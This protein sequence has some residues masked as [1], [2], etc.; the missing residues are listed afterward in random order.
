MRSHICAMMLIGILGVVPLCYAQP[1]STNTSIEEVKK[2]TQ[3]L[4]Q[5]IGSYTADQK[6]EA[7]Q[8][9]KDSLNKLDVIIG[10]D[11]A[12]VN[13][14]KVHLMTGEKTSRRIGLLK[15]WCRL[16]LAELNGLR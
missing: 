15:E 13:M 5:T 10:A 16:R 1:E 12:S 4:L 3:D 11:V 7:V 8:K 2:E 6:D 9:A 14:N